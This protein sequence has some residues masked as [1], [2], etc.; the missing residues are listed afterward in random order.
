MIIPLGSHDTG[1]EKLREELSEIMQYNIINWSIPFYIGVHESLYLDS[2]YKIQ[3]E[4]LDRALI[5]NR[6]IWPI[7]LFLTIKYPIKLIIDVHHFQSHHL[8]Y[9]ALQKI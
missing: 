6:S 8:V 9:F 4:L 1:I 5:L 7:R 3:F 2:T